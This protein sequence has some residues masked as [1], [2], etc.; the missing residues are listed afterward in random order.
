MTT[1]TSRSVRHDRWSLGLLGAGA[2][3]SFALWE[4]LPERIPV[5]FDLHGVAD[6]FASKPVGAFLLPVLGAGTLALLRLA[7][8]WFSPSWRE[9][10][11]A[12]P[13]SLVGLLTS[14]LLAGLHVVC[15]GSAVHPGESAARPLGL[16]LATF[17]LAT[18][19]VLPRVRRNPMVGIRTA[20]TLSS[21]E[22]WARTHRFA[23]LLGAAGSVVGLLGA[24]LGYLPLV[25][26]SVLASGLGAAAYS[27]VLSRREPPY[28]R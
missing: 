19:L 7:P 17:W 23:G 3:L 18:S 14:G 16:V 15:L 22:N 4:Q 2:A 5:H 28:A 9:R 13:M 24:A 8:R 27:F 25:V 6:G 12:S 21:D 26:V 1:R 20:W 10:A 11:D